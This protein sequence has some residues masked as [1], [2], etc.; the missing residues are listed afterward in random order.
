M[1]SCPLLVS[2]NAPKL[3][4]GIETEGRQTDKQTDRK[5]ERENIG[6]LHWQKKAAKEADKYPASSWFLLC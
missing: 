4:Y 5:A 3:Q 6:M 1:A 2:H